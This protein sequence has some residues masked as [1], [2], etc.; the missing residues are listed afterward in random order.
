MQRQDLSFDS[1]GVTCRGYFYPGAGDGARPCIIMG[2]GFAAT[3]DCGL[4]PFAEA[5]AAAGY[6]VFVFD[7]RHFGA[8]GGEPRQ[9]LI[10]EREVEDWLS[11]LAFVRRLDGV[12]AEA[13]CLWGTSFGGGLVTVA[14]ARDG[15]V[16]AVIAQCPMMDGLA[17][18]R[19]VIGYAGLGQVLRLSAH[20]VVDVLRSL[21]GA[22]PHYIASAGRPGDVAAMSAED[23]HDGY[24]AL[25]PPEAP[26]KVAARIATRLAL[27]R[28]VREAAK[29]RCPALLLLCEQDTVAPLAAA[30]KAAARMPLAEVQRYPVG[31][32][33]VYLGEARARSLRDQLDFLARHLPA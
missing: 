24:T 7:Y 20:G 13:I 17:S 23:C 19:A 21:V 18:V 3:R 25:L 10:P 5:F 4:A 27:F 30:E 1:H 15:Q 29:V 8:S 9:L 2:H 16:Q 32:F 6:S 22:S 28:P 12:R 33:D 31:H 11:A 26:N 14:A